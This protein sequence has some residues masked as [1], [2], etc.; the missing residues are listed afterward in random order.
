MIK[1]FRRVRQKLLMENKTGKYLKYAFGEILLVVIGILIALQINTWNENRKLAKQE[2]QALMNI[3]RDFVKGNELLD[4]VIKKTTLSIQSGYQILGYTGS[5]PK[6]A[7]EEDFNNMLNEFFNSAPYYPQNGFLVDLIS[8]GK[9]TII[10]NVQLR[11]LLSSWEPRLEINNEK[12]NSVFRD[13]SLLNNFILDH[14]SWLNADQLTSQKRSIQF[15]ASGF[16]I[17]NRR[18]LDE[19]KFENLTE[20]YMI[21][22]D[23]YLMDLNETAALL[24]RILIL[25]EEEIKTIPK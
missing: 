16:K 3:H 5:K 13:E 17:D 2:Q 25:L 19:L 24:K 18:M 11:N 20:N 15:P 7:S 1:I 8:A 22:G 12:Y 14:G 10:Q 21:A 4:E 6:P 9:L 23:N